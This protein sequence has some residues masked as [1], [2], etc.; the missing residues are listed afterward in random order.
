MKIYIHT[1]IEGVTNVP[2]IKYIPTANPE[3]KIACK[4]LALDTNAAIKGAFDAGAD[5]VTVMDGHG[6]G[7]NMTPDMLDPRVDFDHR[8]SKIWWGKMDESYDATII[9]GAHAMAG[10]QN[11]FLD[12]TQSSASWFNYYINGRPSGEMAQ[13]AMVA[14]H[15]NIPLIMVSGDEAAVAE[16][17]NFFGNI[18]CAAVKRAN[19]RNQ[20][21]LYDADE[22][23]QKIYQA[24]YNAVKA[25]KEGKKFKPYKPIFPAEI[26]IE[27][28]RAD[29][30]EELERAFPWVER[31]DARTV[32]AIIH[33]GLGWYLGQYDVK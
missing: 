31:V 25:L 29:Y 20:A 19:G 18:E 8:E 15:F 5:V 32:R 27:L 2:D 24:T 26:K 9:I 10:T 1:D 28:C 17:H 23:R 22:A 16:A 11:A 12:H 6:G 14:G 30:A 7:G 4:E 13:W 21:I 33:S 3:Y